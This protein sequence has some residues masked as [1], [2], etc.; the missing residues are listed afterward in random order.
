MTEIS[1][2]RD[3]DPADNFARRRR[4][5]RKFALQALYQSDLSRDWAWNEKR[6]TLFWRLVEREMAE[7]SARPGPAPPAPSVRAFAQELVAGVCEHRSELDQRIQARASNWT[8]ERMNAVDRNALRLAAYELFHRPD[9]PPVA[10][11]DE[12]IELAK[13]FGDKN[14]GRFVNG[15]LDAL[16]RDA[17]PPTQA[18]EEVVE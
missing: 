6:W 4:Q 9:I 5:A 11:V 13:T 17:R 8:L 1:S 12:A 10:A 15:V 7:S 16:L 3:P 2:H 18:E 14:S